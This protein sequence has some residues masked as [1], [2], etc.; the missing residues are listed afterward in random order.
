MSIDI[1]TRLRAVDINET[2][3]ELRDVDWTAIKM[4]GPGR[5]Q[6]RSFVNDERSLSRVDE[7]KKAY[8]SGIELPPMILEEVK[9]ITGAHDLYMVDG[10]H[11]INGLKL[12]NGSAPKEI[13]AYVITRVLSDHERSALTVQA[14]SNGP[15]PMTTGETNA[16]ILDS[17]EQGIKIPTIA[18]HYGVSRKRVE[19][20]SRAGN[21]DR[22]LAELGVKERLHPDLLRL[23]TSTV[24]TQI[25]KHKDREAA[26]R[27]GLAISLINQGRLPHIEFKRAFKAVKDAGH[28]PDARREQLGA[29]DDTLKAASRPRTK[30]GRLGHASLQ[31]LKSEAKR[32]A[33]RE[34]DEFQRLAIDT[35]GRA[36][37]ETLVH[38]ITVALEASHG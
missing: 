5:A 25:A 31:T 34:D 30:S 21:A 14:N 11:R 16:L 20:V 35:D 22:A 1:E 6:K 2:D 8:E 3:F 4:G 9:G 27:L 18:A 7:F 23:D 15:L 19:E 37:L 13:K 10:N 38:K 24:I 17:L 33:G 29:L 32:F 12:L 28:D 26:Q 36:S